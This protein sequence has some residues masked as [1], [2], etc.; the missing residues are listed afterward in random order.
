MALVYDG[1]SGDGYGYGY[2]E[3]ETIGPIIE[4]TSSSPHHYE[5]MALFNE[6]AQIKEI[7]LQSHQV[8]EALRAEAESVLQAH[9]Q[10]AQ[11]YIQQVEQPEP[12][13]FFPFLSMPAGTTVR[14]L[15]DGGRLFTLID[16]VLVRANADNSIVCIGLDASTMVLDPARGGVVTLP[17]GRKL[18]LHPSV[19]IATH[20]AAGIEGL[21]MDIDPVLVAEGRYRIDLPDGLRL[22]VNQEARLATFSNPTGTIDILGIGQIAGVGEKITVRLLSGG[23][24][25]FSCEESGHGGLIETDGTIHLSLKGGQELVI[26]FPEAPNLGEDDTDSIDEPSILICERRDS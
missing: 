6:L 4:Q 25:G 26:R 17:D 1:D 13:E 16:G 8:S 10:S 21:P 11:E 3:D 2:G 15:P 18:T 19:L 7:L 24:K 23:A 22:D 12:L 20:E 14:D 9:A 5:L